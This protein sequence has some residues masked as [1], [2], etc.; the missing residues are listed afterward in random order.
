MKLKKLITIGLTAVMAVSAMSTGALAIDNADE[1]VYTYADENNN[2]VNITQAELDAEHWD[3]DAL[4]NVL[5]FIYADFP[6]IISDFVNDYSDLRLDLTYLRKI[7]DADNASL[8]I[9]NLSD[10]IDIYSADITTN[11]FSSPNLEMNK[12]YRLI[13]SETF[14]GVTKEYNKVITTSDEEAKMPDYVKNADTDDET[15]IL[16]GDVDNLRAS[17]VISEDGEAE[18]N[19]DMPR[20]EKVK[21]CELSEYIDNLPSDKLY[22]IYTRDKANNKYFGFISTRGDIDGIF[23]PSITVY[24]WEDFN[25]PAPYTE[26]SSFTPEEIRDGATTPMTQYRDYGFG[27]SSSRRKFEVF[28]FTIPEQH[29]SNDIYEINIHANKNVSI[30]IWTKQKKNN[31]LAFQNKDFERSGFLGYTTQMFFRSPS[32][33]QEEYLEM[34]DEYYVVVYFEGTFSNAE[35]SISI[36]CKD[37]TDDVTGSAYEAFE[38]WKKGNHQEYQTYTPFITTNDNDADVFF[39]NC[40]TSS[41]NNFVKVQNVP[42]KESSK[43]NNNY[44]QQGKYIELAH[45]ASNFTMLRTSTAPDDI[46]TLEPTQKRVTFSTVSKTDYMKFVYIYNAPIG[47]KVINDIYLLLQYSKDI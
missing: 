27:F 24:T 15:I 21:A 6:M 37:D 31:I 23:M 5:P 25:S 38:Q 26:I 40:G 19:T 32:S 35:G 42:A 2:D 3:K 1:V 13:I 45:T 10:D 47:K 41:K 34:G 29:D 46:M 7:S 39:L 43:Y 12:T 4:G 28:K 44:T 14:D 36:Q 30:E 18:I 20:Y 16:V 8:I 17:V 11:S 22:R 33:H 9:K